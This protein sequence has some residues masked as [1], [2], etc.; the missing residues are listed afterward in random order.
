MMCILCETPVASIPSAAPRTTIAD[1]E[2][3]W[4]KIRVRFDSGSMDPVLGVKYEPE[5]LDLVYLVR[6][7]FSKRIQAIEKGDR[8]DAGNKYGPEADERASP[9]A[10]ITELK[11]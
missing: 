3:L 5:G 2:H 9:M 1:I 8:D 7:F 10:M 6:R 4:T 11:K